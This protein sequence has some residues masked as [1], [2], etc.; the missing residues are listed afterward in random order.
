MLIPDAETQVI[1]NRDHGNGKISGFM[2]INNRKQM[3]GETEII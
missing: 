1:D 3:Q 2:Y